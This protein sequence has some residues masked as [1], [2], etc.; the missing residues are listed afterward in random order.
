MRCW[1]GQIERSDI[2]DQLLDATDAHQSRADAGPAYYPLQRHLCRRRTDVAGDA[3]HLVDDA[4]VTIGE[5]RVAERIGAVETLVVLRPFGR[6]RRG[7]TR[8]SCATY[9]A[10]AFDIPQYCVFPDRTRDAIVSMSSSAGV[11]PSQVC[12]KYISR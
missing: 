4:P 9:Q 8:Q 5:Q 12:T 10:G 3:D 11:T 1:N 7:V 2:V 6:S